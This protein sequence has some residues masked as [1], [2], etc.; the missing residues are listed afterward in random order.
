[1]ALPT[2]SPSSKNATMI[3]PLSGRELEVL[4]LVATGLTNREIGLRLHLQISNY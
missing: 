3:E 2:D 4:Q 1:M